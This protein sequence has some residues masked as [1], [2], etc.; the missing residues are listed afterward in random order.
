MG[1]IKLKKLVNENW[2]TGPTGKF[3]GDEVKLGKIYTDKD[4]PPFQVKES[5]LE[6]GTSSLPSRLKLYMN[7]FIDEIK[8][9]K[10]SRKKEIAVLYTTIKGLGLTPQE[11]QM[12]VS[13]VKK[14]I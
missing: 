5:G 12:Y 4:R 11:V 2:L 10:L 9:A 3:G 13:R 1:K 14:E 6:K 8:K 7:K